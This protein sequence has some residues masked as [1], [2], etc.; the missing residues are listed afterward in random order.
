MKLLPY[1]FL[2]RHFG[3]LK[4]EIESISVNNLLNIGDFPGLLVLWQ[5][6]LTDGSEKEVY[7]WYSSTTKELIIESSDRV[8]VEFIWEN[9]E[10]L[11]TFFHSLSFCGDQGEVAFVYGLQ[12]SIGTVLNS[13]RGLE[14]TTNQ[15][16]VINTKG[17]DI[18]AKVF[19]N[20]NK[21]LTE[22]KLVAKI[23][24]EGLH[25]QVIGT[26][27]I[28]DVKG[29][30]SGTLSLFTHNQ[31]NLQNLDSLTGE[32][33][34]NFINKLITKEEC[35]DFLHNYVDLT[36]ATLNQFH[37]QLE[38]INNFTEKSILTLRS[39][40]DY[41]LHLPKRKEIQSFGIDIEK[42]FFQEIDNFVNHNNI[43]LIHGDIWWRQ[44][45]IDKKK[46]VYILDLEDSEIGFLGYDIGSWLNS[47]SQQAEYFSKD[48]DAEQCKIIKKIGKTIISSLEKKLKTF[49][50][51]KHISQTEIDLGR[52]LRSIHELNYLLT[53]QTS[54][55][56][57]VEFIKNEVIELTN[58]KE[59]PFEVDI[60]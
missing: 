57:L 55:N 28:I 1:P 39:F 48:L 5:I 6:L 54:E 11:N 44:F 42:S 56:W 34:S 25:P 23:A 29:K 14:E 4:E 12:T 17:L 46:H 22:A 24:Y 7:C 60:T 3:I 21:G 50:S 37:Y 40:T 2:E 9:P 53:H 30:P 10:D 27:D 20:L 18:R 8:A 51:Y 58:R 16:F 31:N 52:Y 32:V 49:D 43:Q 41:F 15:H 47:I 13:T 26:L 33:Y 19:S 38:K 36:L 35:L 45:V 59:K